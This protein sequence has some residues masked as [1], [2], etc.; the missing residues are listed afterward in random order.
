MMTHVLVMGSYGGTSNIIL[1]IIIL[2]I[3]VM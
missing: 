3:R 2:M 1:I